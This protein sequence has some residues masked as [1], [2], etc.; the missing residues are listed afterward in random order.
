MSFTF[1]INPCFNLV[2]FFEIKLSI[3][4]EKHFITSYLESSNQCSII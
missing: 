4:Y 3:K 2:I 1:K